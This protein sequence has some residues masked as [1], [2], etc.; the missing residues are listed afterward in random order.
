MRVTVAV[1]MS[2]SFCP[3]VEDFAPALPMCKPKFLSKP[4]I[5]FSRSRVVFTNWARLFRVVGAQ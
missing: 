1:N 2:T 5:W 4:G 3:M